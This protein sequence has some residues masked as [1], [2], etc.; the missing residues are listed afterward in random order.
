M[1]IRLL[2]L[3][4]LL[5]TALTRANAALTAGT[6]YYIWLNIYEKLLGSNEAGDGPSLSAWGVNT[7]GDSYVFVA[8][9]CGKSGYVL[10]KQKSSG[11]YLAASGSNGWSMT[12]EDRSTDDRFCWK[13]DAG[14]YTYL[15]NKK[16]SKYMGIDGAQKGSKYVSVYYDK[17][18]GSH[19]QLTIIP[20]AGGDYDTARA[21]YVSAQYVNKQ[22]VQ[23]VDYIRL[24]GKNISRNDAV[25]IHLTAN[26]DP[27]DESSRVNLGSDR[28]WL[29]FD[30][31]TP[32]NVKDNFLQY[33]TINGS[34]A[35]ADS[36]GG[37][38]R[39]AI[40]LN[41]AAVIPIP[42]TIFQASGNNS[43][44]LG[45]GS[46]TD[47]A[48][49]SNSMTSFTLRRGYMATLATGRKGSGFSRVYVADH[50]DISVSLPQGLAQRVT[51]VY[52]KPW[53]YV[54]KKGWGNTAG[55]SGGPGLRA[56]WYWSWSADYWSTSDM[57]Y[58]PCRQHRWWPS[59]SQVNEH[60][61]S[62]TMS[63]NEPEHSEQHNKSDCACSDNWTN[64]TLM[65]DYQASGARIGSCQ[66]T[67]FSY[68]NTFF[69]H[70]DD[71]AYRCDFAITHA[72]W[73]LGGRDANTY[74]NWFCDT[75]C[76]SIWNNTKRPVWLTEMEVSA[77]WNSNKIDSYEKNRQYLQA[78][79]QKIDECPWIERY[80]IY[81]TDMW[82]TYMYYDANPSKG[83]T[84]AGQVYRDHRATFA[85]DASYTKEPIWW[86]PSIKKPSISA[87]YDNA[88][89][90][91]NFTINNP[92]TDATQSLIV[93][94]STN[95][96]S[97][98]QVA[99]I[100]DRVT[101]E[102]TNLKLNDI[103]IS[104][105]GMG[106]KFR[107]KVSTLFGGSSESDVF[108]IGS[109]VNGSINATSRTDIYGWTC[110]RS[111]DNG[112]TKGESGD[113]YFEAWSASTEGETFDYYQE[114][115]GLQ[116]GVYSLQAKVFNST[117]GVSGASINGAVGL[118][119]QTGNTIWFAPV[120][121][122]SE[123]AAA[124]L[125]KLDKIVVR[126]GKL[127]LGVRNLK[128]MTARWAGADDFALTYRGTVEDILST[129]PEEAII[130]ARS[131]FAEQMEEME[132]GARNLSFMLHN[133]DCARN[134]DG[135]TATNVEVKNGQAYDGQND[136]P[137][138]TYF[139]RWAADAYESS[140][141]QTVDNLPPGKYVLSAILRSASSFSLQLSATNGTD[142]ASKDFTGTG[143]SGGLAN[144]GWVV[145]TLD[146][147]TLEEG[148]SLTVSLTGSGTSWWSADHFQLAY[149]PTGLPQAAGLAF[150]A[151]T[152]TAVLG[153]DFEAPTLDNPNQLAVTYSSS[154]EAVAIVD[155]AGVV[156]PIAVG[157]AVIT[158]SFAGNDDFMAGS[159]SYT[160]T[161]EA[162]PAQEAGLA[163]AVETATAVLGQDF[164]APTLQNPNQLTVTWSSSDEAVA[165]VDAEGVVT[166]VAAGTT[167]ISAA[168]EGN[169]EY[170][171]ATVSYQL[172]VVES[173]A[174]EPAGLAFA[175]ETAEATLGEDFEAPV[176]ENP[177]QLTVVWS[178]SDEAV[179]T[180]DEAGVITLLAAGTTVITATFEG[181]DEYLPGSASYTLTVV[182][183]DA[184]RAITAATG[185][186]T[187]Y[188][189]SGIRLGVMPKR[190]GIYIINGKK[191][192]VK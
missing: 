65:P 152:A 63:I 51:S 111:A 53:H 164:E 127:R 187:V 115:T 105:V 140:L 89:G 84:P 177:N 2:M 11:K 38:C 131:A 100:T 139:D 107:V 46:H 70:V 112:Y 146:E 93:E 25:D 118:Y 57:E 44:T 94:M 169:A 172:T 171:A 74:A 138:N 52:V 43:F 110:V 137:K 191:V 189:I 173:Q 69:G 168:F 62:A 71:M 154:D 180:I 126:D 121:K 99:S 97:W 42:A 128:A 162:Q 7:D 188:T 192:V 49:N 30:N 18:S 109:L 22:G 76:K 59:V 34:A 104:G 120:T 6:E 79:L 155:E 147:I 23:E 108:E 5:A 41:G 26:E 37:N 55:S 125:L 123:M 24:V 14:V 122:D 28:T 157:T 20:T 106:T 60:A 61:S 183:P 17:P 67:D 16:N 39:V 133:P 31:V 80:A 134:T 156:T 175:V 82:Q 68:L 178:S 149:T 113:T 182:E 141:T 48:E 130:A 103:A 116:D 15:Q 83:L 166:L 190:A 72:Y 40:Y 184:V 90:T 91:A 75:Q 142:T 66:P 78:L 124:D 8:E 132:S 45:K 33:V 27:M 95:G 1:K 174:T 64:C 4:A 135:W 54:S 159:A 29:I 165:T 144:K 150:S 88:A 35:N 151:E 92:N 21:A 163:F 87:T 129:T 114:L 98:Q 19:S 117:N 160:L 9:D 32:K 158:A 77:S 179:A 50:A 161:V 56:T 36:D 13:A 148:Q 167:V 170:L 86:A 181:N 153:S 101:L 136:N 119:A 47:L 58:V 145:V 73:D 143:D 102:D 176:L 96:T 185:P 85:Y 186:L 3:A 10:L 12:L 81:G